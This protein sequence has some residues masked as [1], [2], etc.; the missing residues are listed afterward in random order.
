MNKAPLKPQSRRT[1]QQKLAKVIK[2]SKRKLTTTKTK[3]QPHIATAIVSTTSPLQS[4]PPSQQVA[5]A[6][7]SA[8]INTS[9]TQPITQPTPQPLSTIST[10]QLPFGRF[11][12]SIRPQQRRSQTQTHNTIAPPMPRFFSSA[13]QLTPPPTTTATTTTTTAAIPAEDSNPPVDPELPAL[14]KQFKRL[15]FQAT[16]RG[17]LELD[18]I[19]TAYV[20]TYKTKLMTQENLDFLSAVCDVDNSDLV[21][22]F[23]EGRPLPDEWKSNPIMVD[24]LDYALQPSKP[25]YPSQSGGNQ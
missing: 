16:Q 2:V 3:A 25:W 11:Q 7:P 14:E 21:R 12:R 4:L 20:K 18:L 8:H 6:T 19:F 15:Y 1:K 5:I 23:V 17:W 22:W 9:S 24:M 10:T 13:P